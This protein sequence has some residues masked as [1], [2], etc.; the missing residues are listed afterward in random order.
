MKQAH[1]A[2]SSL[3]WLDTD[4]KQTRRVADAL[5]LLDDKDVLD[6]LGIGVVRDAFAEALF[7]GTSTIQ[8]R[9]RYFVFAPWICQAVA[10]S[11]PDRDSF[12]RRLRRHEV[13]LIEA[14]RR[15]TGYGDGVIGYRARQ[16]VNRLPTSVYWHGLGVW[17][18]RR[19]DNLSISRYRDLVSAYGPG[20]GPVRRDDD[21][22]VLD[23]AAPLWDPGI[24]EPPNHFPDGELRLDLTLAEALY[25]QERMRSTRLGMVGATESPSLLALLADTPGIAEGIDEPWSVPLPTVPEPVAALLTHAHRFSEAIH[26]AQL[27]YNVLLAQAGRQR[28][29][30]DTDGLADRARDQ[31]AGWSERMS[32]DESAFTAWWSRRDEFWATVRAVG[33]RPR[34]ATYGFLTRWIGEAVA[35]PG[36]VADDPELRAAVARQEQTLKGRYARLT[37]LAALAAWGGEPL[38][39]APQR[40]RWPTV[41]MFLRDLANGLPAEGTH[42]GTR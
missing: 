11:R 17:G 18:L 6:P 31:L 37:S 24:P 15:T 8:T 26:G 19:A 33:G 10:R 27:L 32:A 21:E 13:R 23:G 9:L 29:D 36:R 42:A 30:R 40:Y 25:L 22:G 3:S 5:R 20:G 14:L 38:A 12:D 2:V 7:P 34:P 16:R 39:W 41:R 4:D 28:L 1:R 35:R